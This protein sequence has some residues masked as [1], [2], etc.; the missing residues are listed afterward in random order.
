MQAIN[1]AVP[2]CNAR[3]AALPLE[4]LACGC[5]SA[6]VRIMHTNA[7]NHFSIVI[8]GDGSIFPEVLIALELSQELHLSQHV[9]HQCLL[10][11]P[12]ISRGVAMLFSEVIPDVPD[13]HG[14]K[15]NKVHCYLFQQYRSLSRKKPKNCVNG[16]SI[17]AIISSTCVLPLGKLSPTD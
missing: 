14:C 2:E 15:A 11:W 7:S 16:F 1:G 4:M 6:S 8:N 9:D 12:A 5:S 3:S 10:T 17:S 13:C